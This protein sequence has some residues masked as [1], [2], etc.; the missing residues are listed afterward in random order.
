[1]SMPGS[2]SEVRI[3]LNLFTINCYNNN[4]ILLYYKEKYKDEIMQLKK[5]IIRWELMI[6]WL[7]YDI[8]QY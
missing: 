1:M 3:E 8:E 4:V 2:G 5:C 7:V 6:L